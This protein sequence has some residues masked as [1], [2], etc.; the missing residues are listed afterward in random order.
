MSF[1]LKNYKF[2]LGT[3]REKNVIWVQFPNDTVLRNELK[4]RFPSVSFSWTNKCWYLADTKHFREH[5]G[6]EAKTVLE[7]I[8]A[9]NISDVNRLALKRMHETLLLKSY[10]ENTIKSYCGEFAQLLQS[11]KNV[12]VG[13]LTPERL[14]SYFLYC[15]QTLKLSENTLHSRLNAIKFYF[16]QVLKREKMFFDEIPRPKKQSL[17]PK[18]LSKQEVVRL[19]AQV[20]NLKHQIMLKLCYGMGLRVSEIVALKITDIDSDR[21]L[22]RIENAK[23]KKD[24]Y[25]PLPQSILDDLRR[26]YKEYQ[27]KEYLFEGQYGVQYSIRS[28]QAVFKTAMNKAKIKK[29][30]GIHGLRHSYATHLLEAGTDMVFIQKLLGHKD[31][32]T[33]QIYAKVTDKQLSRVKSPLDSL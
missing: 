15:T 31:V 20:E 5:V 11:L 22:V 18:V 7:S 21:M 14:R 26:Y 32:K 30:V 29:T 3:H 24:R 9:D 17:L 25:T 16:E 27:P 28:V 6:L 4:E 12:E 33:T 13:T 19:F 1:E 10:S 23:G 2:A 8:Q